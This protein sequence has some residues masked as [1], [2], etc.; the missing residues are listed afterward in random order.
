MEGSWQCDQMLD[1]KEAQFCK[2]LPKNV[3]KVDF[4]ITIGIVQIWHKKSP[5]I[6][7]IFERKIVAIIFQ[8]GLNPVTQ[9]DEQESVKSFFRRMIYLPT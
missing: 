7:T 1:C 6:W 3:A 9:V 5:N 4:Y 8:K 2:K